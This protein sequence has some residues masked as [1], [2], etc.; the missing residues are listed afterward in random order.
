[1]KPETRINLIKGLQKIKRINSRTSYLGAWT[2]LIIFGYVL[3]TLIV[4]PWGDIV[5]Q[6]LYWLPSLIILMV[7]A[8][9]LQSFFIIIRYL[10]YK[11]FLIIF[12]ALL[13]DK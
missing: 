6:E 13:D 1:M 8:V 9:L 7:L 4:K 12:E 10:I 5:N 3:A 2:G 11:R